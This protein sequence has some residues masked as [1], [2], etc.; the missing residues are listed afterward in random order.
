[1]A[2]YFVGEDVGNSDENAGFLHIAEFVVDSR[3][4]GPHRGRK[5]HVGVNQGRNG[6]AAPADFVVQ[7]FEILAVG[8]AGE[9][10]GEG[11]GG[12][13]GDQGLDGADKRVGI[14]K[15]PVQEI[16]DH[17]PAFA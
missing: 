10:A 8:A 15:V 2:G 13:I 17:V 3:A 11:I 7:D 5:A 14:G 4:E 12:R 1:M 6:G 9:K 16:E